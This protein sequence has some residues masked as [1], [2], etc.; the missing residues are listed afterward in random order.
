MDGAGALA[1]LPLQAP[2]GSDVGDE[3][4]EEW[5]D[6]SEVSSLPDLFLC[7]TGTGS[8]SDKGAAAKLADGHG[9][10]SS[11]DAAASPAYWAAQLHDA[12][13]ECDAADASGRADTT[14]APGAHAGDAAAGAAAGAAAAAAGAASAGAAPPAPASTSPLSISVVYSNVAPAHEAAVRSAHMAAGAALA[15][16]FPAGVRVEV[17]R[18][19]TPGSTHPNRYEDPN[20]GEADGGDDEAW[21]GEAAVPPSTL[22]ARRAARRAGC[23]PVARAPSPPPPQQQHEVHLLPEVLREPRAAAVL[24]LGLRS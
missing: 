1:A 14:D 16:L 3:D 9:G 18:A 17:K 7:P 11:M 24:A 15:H 13:A 8:G 23:L 12:P 22:R 4:D 5:G 21:R 20:E 6:E 10:S 19:E 2:E